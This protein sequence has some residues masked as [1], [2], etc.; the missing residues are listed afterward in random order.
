MALPPPL[1]PCEKATKGRIIKVETTLD[2]PLAPAEARG[3]LSHL[4]TAKPLTTSTNQLENSEPDR[5][6]GLRAGRMREQ[7]G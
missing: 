5:A 4:A 3:L 1:P 6:P 2:R 7:Q